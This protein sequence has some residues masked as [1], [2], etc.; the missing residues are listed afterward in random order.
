[1]TD[2][3]NGLT[4]SQ[5][6]DATPN[7]A[8]PNN[9]T[10][11]NVTPTNVTATNAT[12]ND[13]INQNLEDLRSA[14]VSDGDIQI[15][16]RA[17]NLPAPFKLFS[18]A[19]WSSEKSWAAVGAAV[20]IAGREL[21]NATDNNTETRKP[22]SVILVATRA[23]ATVLFFKALNLCYGTGV[24]P[25]VL[26]GTSTEKESCPS[27]VEQRR[28]LRNRGGCD[29]VI[30]TPGRFFHM[31]HSGV[32]A[33]DDIRF[34]CLEEA[35]VFALDMWTETD[36]FQGLGFFQNLA[37]FGV[38]GAKTSV[39]CLGTGLRRGDATTA[40]VRHMRLGAQHRDY[41]A[42]HTQ[43]VHHA[44][45]VQQHFASIQDG[46]VLI[47]HAASL[48][49]V[50]LLGKMKTLIFLNSSEERPVLEA[51]YSDIIQVLKD[52]G[53]ADAEQQVGIHAPFKSQQHNESI[54][55]DFSLGKKVNVLV[56]S[57]L[58]AS[59]PHTGGISNVLHIG[60]PRHWIPYEIRLQHVAA[61]T[62]EA[63]GT[64]MAL[65]MAKDA[66]EFPEIARSVARSK[67]SDQEAK[68]RVERE[69]LEELRRPSQFDAA[70][71]GTSNIRERVYNPKPER[72]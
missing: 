33:L 48:V 39:L 50:I 59:L 9:A 22:T 38:I 24:R 17:W 71:C 27:F 3:I 69:T 72:P 63:S 52:L 43:D 64:S 56:G 13:R 51:F 67:A 54:L 14:G 55:A 21:Q 6:R 49:S 8:A 32:T 42:L 5:T 28:L 4:I 47:A 35:Q 57:Q 7:D 11:T 19:T 53:V 23:Q 66:P 58:L 45:H 25:R 60:L 10:P 20:K 31:I 30:A 62:V 44:R 36:C 34:L 2:S 18:D 61:Q 26:Y 65:V 68:T 70:S 15:I 1:M 12:P 37:K 41:Q 16:R 29:V 46:R 40:L